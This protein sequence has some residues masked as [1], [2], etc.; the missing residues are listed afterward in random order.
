MIE[1]TPWARDI[2]NR[3]QAAARRFHPD[4]KIRLVRGPGGVEARLTDEASPDDEPVDAGG[5][6]LFVERGLEGLVDVEEPHDRL[7]LRPLGSPPNIRPEH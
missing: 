2:L 4:A 6:T 7:V 1:V 5:M 3:S